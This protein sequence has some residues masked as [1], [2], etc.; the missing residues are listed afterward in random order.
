MREYELK[1]MLKKREQENAA[2][3]AS[4]MELIQEIKNIHEINMKMNEAR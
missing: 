1:E 2:E 4:K 3:L